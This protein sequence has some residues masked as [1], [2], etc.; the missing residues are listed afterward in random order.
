MYCLQVET[1]ASVFKGKPKACGDSIKDDSAADCDAAICCKTGQTK[2]N[3][4]TAASTCAERGY[5]PK[6]GILYGTTT[7]KSKEFAM[8]LGGRLTSNGIDV[9]MKVGF[10]MWN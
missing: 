3:P 2:E 4:Q 1:V 6:V 10:F 5:T 9:E 8:S 7:G